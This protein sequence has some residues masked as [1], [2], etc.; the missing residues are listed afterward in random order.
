M[1]TRYVQTFVLKQP[2]RTGETWP[3]YVSRVTSG[4]MDFVGNDEMSAMRAL[5]H[6]GYC[7]IEIMAIP[8]DIDPDKWI[9]HL[10]RIARK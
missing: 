4:Q 3:D 2:K 7:S 1:S 10:D 6:G 8:G 5:I 9:M